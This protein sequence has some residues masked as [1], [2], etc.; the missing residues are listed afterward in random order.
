M[1]TL[2]F[3]FAASLA[4][5]ILNVGC[6]ELNLTETTGNQDQKE[7]ETLS[8]T[9]GE[10][11]ED[12]FYYCFDEKIPL[13]ERKDLVFLRFED[14]TA[15]ESFLSALEDSLGVFVSSE[16]S[17]AARTLV[18]QSKEDTFP[19]EQIVAFRQDPRIAYFSF[20]SES[21]GRYS[22]VTNEFS[23]KVKSPASLRKLESLVE[24]YECEFYRAAQLGEDE[25]IVQIPKDSEW[26]TLQLA[27]L[28]YEA[29]GFE[30]TSPNFYCF[31]T[32]ATVDP[33]YGDQWGLNNNGH[34]LIYPDFDINIEDAW[35][36]TEGS[37][38]IIV[39][40]LDNGVDLY[41]QDL[42]ANLVAGDDSYAGTTNGAP[43]NTED[44]HGTAVAGI[45]GAIKDNGLGIRGV[46]PGC[47]IMPV[48]VCEGNGGD[49][50]STAAGL[51]WAKNSGADV[52]NCS[53]VFDSSYSTIINAINSVTSS[54]RNGKGCVVVV[55]SGNTNSSVCFPATL[56]N[57]MAVGAI[58]FDGNRVTPSSPGVIYSWGS[59]YGPELDVV[60]PGVQIPTTDP[61]GNDG[62]NPDQNSPITDYSDYNYTKRMGGTSAAT[63]H[64]SGVAALILSEYPDLTE[65]QVR[66]AI[67]LGCTKWPGYTYTMDNLYPAA[68]RNNEMGYGILNAYGALQQASYLH[69]QN[70]LDATSGFDFVITNNSSYLVDDIYI[71]V[72]GYVGGSYTTLISEDPGGVESG[73]YIGYPVYRG[74]N[75][76]AVAGTTISGIELEFYASVP[77]YSGYLRI[78]VAIDNPSPYNY[79]NYAFGSGNTYQLNLS[80]TTV[81]SASRRTVYI[82]ILNQY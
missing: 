31:N 63:P 66:R 32:L 20:I 1:K 57:V 52:I 13:K 27:C 43:G 33:Y 4:S 78:G 73:K 6:T 48:R 58:S 53:W 37:S 7:K 71:G 49:I 64:V 82:N 61:T 72:T 42:A 9:K 59:N 34:S 38:D 35:E 15:K 24:E 41:H 60:A 2:H 16:V 26:D 79:Y 30:F 46:A 67:E 14:V 68:T 44:F 56:S 25:Y 62:L 75:L 69:Q 70:V 18:L 29:G 65:S 51:Y 80:N 55:A 77:D 45:V 10:A 21:L 40:V 19:S 50:F 28:F 76:S 36:I 74:E 39:A 3:I 5:F 17:G 47:K 12:L 22:A 54:G 23:V 8:M 81:P 11:E